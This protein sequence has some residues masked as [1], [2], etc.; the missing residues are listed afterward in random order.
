MVPGRDMATKLCN[1]SEP[2]SCMDTCCEFPQNPP[3]VV[4][5]ATCKDF[6]CPADSMVKRP[7]VDDLTC[8]P[9]NEN[10]CLRACCT[11]KPPPAPG[12]EPCAN[13]NCEALHPGFQ[14]DPSAADV[15]CDQAIEGQ[16]REVR[17]V[18]HSIQI[19]GNACE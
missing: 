10:G 9:N 15:E 7:N 18:F 14:N 4:P 5:E 16:C 2:T 3:P 11:A 13:Y 19:P 17:A 8:D 12:P 1:A 6:T